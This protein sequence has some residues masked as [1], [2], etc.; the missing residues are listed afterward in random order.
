MKKINILIICSIFIVLLSSCNK[1][2]SN[3]TDSSSSGTSLQTNQKTM[4]KELK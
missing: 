2:E 1:Q 3:K 4:A